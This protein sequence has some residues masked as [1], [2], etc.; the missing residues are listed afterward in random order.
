V[1]RPLLLI[2][3]VGCTGKVTVFEDDIDS[4]DTAVPV[5]TADTADTGEPDEPAPAP[6]TTWLDPVSLDGGTFEMGC[7]RPAEWPCEDDERPSH[8]VT[9]APFQILRTE[10]PRGM[11]RSLTGSAPRPPGCTQDDCVLAGVT[12]HEAVAF[13]NLVSEAEGLTPAYQISGTTVTWD[14]SADGWRLPTESEW[15][16]AARGNR[17]LLYAGSSDLDQVA[18]TDDNSG[19]RP[20][21]FGEKAPNDYDLV[22]MSGNVWEWVWDGYGA[23]PD[24]PT[25]NPQGDATSAT[26]VVRGGGWNSIGDDARVSARAHQAPAYAELDLGFRIVRGA[27]VSLA[28]PPPP[29]TEPESPRP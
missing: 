23:Y 13:C 6:Y 9:L 22:D 2:T 29:R 21:V 25:E 8:T 5:D 12:W 16:Y 15:E 14:T 28:G 24:S 18:W 26:K 20:H 27:L 11:Y 10:V 7:T 17:D 4:A 1:L 19:G 3:V